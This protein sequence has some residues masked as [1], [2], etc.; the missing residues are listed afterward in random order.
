[1]L[2]RVLGPLAEEIRPAFNGVDLVGAV[3][4]H[5]PFALIV[6][7]VR[8]PWMS[9]LEAARKLRDAGI[10]TPILFMTG[11]AGAEGVL[12]ALP[13]ALVLKK[14]FTA[15]SLVQAVLRALAITDP[16]ST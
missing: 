6:T 7:D 13:G 8:M 10:E 9:G 14:P 1:M 12:E 4:A 3:V 11:Y 15:E 5:G 2:S 16:T